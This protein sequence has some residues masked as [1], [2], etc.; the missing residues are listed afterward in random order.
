V[1]VERTVVRLR[2]SVERRWQA[3]FSAASVESS[4]MTPQ[5]RPGSLAAS[6][7]WLPAGGRQWFAVE[8]REFGLLG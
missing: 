2:N 7:V 6:P 4:E 8:L 3:E 1:E 5:A